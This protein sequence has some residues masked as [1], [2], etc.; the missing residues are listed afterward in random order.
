GVV[1][2]ISPT[3]ALTV[4]WVLIENLRLMRSLAG[5]YGGRPGFVGTLRLARMVLVHIIATGGMALTDDLL[6]Q[7]LGQDLVRRLSRRLGESI[8]NAAL[9]ARVGAAAIAVTRPLPFIEAPPIRARD[10]IGE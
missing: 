6:G 2:A 10:F 3:A 5:V 9:T 4:G 8:F 1:S 7:F